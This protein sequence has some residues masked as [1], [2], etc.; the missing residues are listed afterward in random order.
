MK[1][2]K[3]KALG[4]TLIELMIVVAIIGILAAI[5]IPSYQDYTNKAKFTEITQALA[6]FKL[7][8]EAC[9]REQSSMKDCVNGAGGIG[10][11]SIPQAID[12]A[13]LPGYVKSI[14]VQPLSDNAVKIVA[15]SQNIGKAKEGYTYI[16]D[17]ELQS[18]GQLLWRKDAQ[19]S[20]VAAGIC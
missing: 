5:A 12:N 11:N 20:C 18:S 16:L 10:Q 4:F 8:V 17:G 7:A 9:A 6:P 19:S 14:S 2:I 15:T 1:I 13:G 3:S